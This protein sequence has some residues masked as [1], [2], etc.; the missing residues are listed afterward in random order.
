MLQKGKQR[1]GKLEWGSH[2]DIAMRR[3]RPE[4]WIFDLESGFP[5]T[6]TDHLLLLTGQEISINLVQSTLSPTF[7]PRLAALVLTFPRDVLRNLKNQAPHSSVITNC[8]SYVLSLAPWHHPF[9]SLLPTSYIF[10]G[11]RNVGD[12]WSTAGYEEWDLGLS[13]RRFGFGFSWLFI[14]Y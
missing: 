5:F 12:S 13:R 6:L 7:R 3:A 10:S 2:T 11:H 4:L 14:Y 8:I 9:P 1:P